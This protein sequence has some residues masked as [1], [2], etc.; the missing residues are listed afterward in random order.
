ML[1]R[2]FASRSSVHVVKYVFDRNISHF[3]RALW[4]IICIASTFFAIYLIH[5]SYTDWQTNQVVTTLKSVAKPVTDLDFPAFTI[6]GAGQHMGNVEKVLYHNFQKWEQNQ[7]DKK[8]QKSPEDSFAEYLKETFQIHKK[9]TSILDIFNTMISP[10]DEASGA[11]SVRRNEE[12]CAA[13][14]QRTKRSIVEKTTS[15]AD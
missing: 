9:G 15:K 12:A 2:D 8:K 7:P 14:N 6:C 13:K 11:N 4:T 10:S 1:T 3:D 5:N